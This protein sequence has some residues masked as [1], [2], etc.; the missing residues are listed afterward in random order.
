[1]HLQHTQLL[2]GTAPRQLMDAFCLSCHLLS[3]FPGTALSSLLPVVF[4]Q[5]PCKFWF[6]THSL[7]GW[8]PEPSCLF[9]MN[10]AV[11]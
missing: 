3:S 11:E 9:T 7:L 1:M 8:T 4:L 10:S 2:L 6:L 5:T